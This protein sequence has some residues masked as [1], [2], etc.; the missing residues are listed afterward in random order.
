MAGHDV[1]TFSF[2]CAEASPRD[3]GVTAYG[4]PY[5]FPPKLPRPLI[6]VPSEQPKLIPDKHATPM[7]LRFQTGS[8]HWEGNCFRSNLEE[9]PLLS[10]TATRSRWKRLPQRL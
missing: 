10:F 7:H 2:R 8:E 4:S 6:G 1:F 9:R 5:L 3:E